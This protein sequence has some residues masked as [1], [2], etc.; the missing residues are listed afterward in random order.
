MGV[1]RKPK[2]VTKK[3]MTGSYRQ[4][5]NGTKT[6][7]KGGLTKTHLMLNKRGK[8][9]SKKSGAAGKKRY[10][11]ALKKWNV[12]LMKARKELGITGF[13]KINRGVEGIKLYKLAKSYTN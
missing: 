9:V 13:V 1:A 12:A 5:W 11:G 6:F 4:V 8:V 2:K 10:S 3:M 7:T